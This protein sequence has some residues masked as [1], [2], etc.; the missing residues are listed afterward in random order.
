MGNNGYCFLMDLIVLS[1]SIDLLF[2]AHIHVTVN[3]N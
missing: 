2:S 1:L 3:L